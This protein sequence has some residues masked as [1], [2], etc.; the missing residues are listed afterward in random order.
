MLNPIPELLTLGFFAPFIL[1]VVA[2]LIF[3]SL[4]YRHAVKE[5]AATT[6]AV[7]ERWGQVGTFF[8]WYLGIAEVTA[9]LLILL[10]L[11]TQ[12]GAVIGAV[13]AVKM[14][15]LK[16]KHAVLAKESTAFY[17]LLLAICLSLLISGAGALAF[18]L[19]L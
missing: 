18:D 4:G 7:N 14:L 12:I 10:G 8:V 9:G 1:R 17:G 6:A 3:L 11:W 15:L 16:R 2:G 19:P 5:R 13:I